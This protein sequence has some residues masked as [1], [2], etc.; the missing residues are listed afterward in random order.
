MTPPLLALALALTPLRASADLKSVWF[1]SRHGSRAPD[2]VVTM[3]CPGLT[4]VVKKF[5]SIGVS[6]SGVTGNGLREMY[7]V[8]TFARERYILEAG[9]LSET[10]DPREIYMDAASEPRTIQSGSTM[11]Q[12]MFAGPAHFESYREPVPIFVNATYGMDNLGETRKAGCALRLARDKQRW[13][14][15]HGAALWKKKEAIVHSL[16]Q[17]CK[18]DLRLAL[19]YSDGMDNLGDAIKDVT[20]LMMFADREG[21]AAPWNMTLYEDAR[22][23]ALEQ[24]YGRLFGTP[25]QRTYMVGMS[26]IAMLEHFNKSINPDEP[27][28]YLK[29]Y[30]YHGHR[31]LL[32]A[33]AAFFKI[34]YH[35]DRPGFRKFGI[36]SGTTLFFELHDINQTDVKRLGVDKDGLHVRLVVY[37]PC[38]KALDKAS[39]SADVLCFAKAYRF[40]FYPS[41]DYVPYDLFRQHIENQIQ[42]TG[43]WKELCDYPP[44]VREKKPPQTCT[45][46]DNN[47]TVFYATLYVAIGAAVAALAFLLSAPWT[48]RC[49]RI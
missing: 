15:T 49:R 31:E 3:V 19:D 44:V 20:D 18:V 4:S 24:L 43:T 5:S 35:F 32:Y 11:G 8:G 6:P 34:T 48:S 46:Q 10:W 36:P 12:G 27:Q 21:F 13:D 41:N 22:A 26:P 9:F 47:N 17:L 29:M 14:E 16:S 30:G 38:K 23:I 37:A 42:S 28:P 1:V 25:Q 7:S 33:L 2:P 40:G 45:D 39:G